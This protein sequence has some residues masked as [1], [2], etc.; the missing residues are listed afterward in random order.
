MT[1]GS[2][3]CLLIPCTDFSQDN[4]PHSWKIHAGWESKMRDAV[5]TFYDDQ[6]RFRHE[7]WK[8]VFDEQNASDPIRL[9]LADPIFGLPIGEDSVEFEN[10]LPKDAIWKRIR[11]LSQFAILEGDELER[12]RE[13]FFEA[14]NS[15][16]TPVDKDG[17]VAIHGR[18]YFAWS[19]RIPEGPLKSG[20]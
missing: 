5:W 11:I 4:A 2:P 19:S 18:T 14:I 8:Q 1:V 3:S 12:R 6:P 16:D 13:E 10:W 15:D 20:G 9:H 17:N 7:K